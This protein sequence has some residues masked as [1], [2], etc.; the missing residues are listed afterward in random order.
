MLSKRTII[1][2]VVG[3]VITG[4]GIFALVLA[5]GTQTSDID[6]NILVGE[7]RAYKFEALKDS[8]EYLLVMGDRF[9]LTITTPGDGLQ[10]LSTTHNDQ[11]EYDWIVEQDGTNR[12]EIKNTGASDVNI[13][14]NFEYQTDPILYA[15]HIMVIIAGV[16][17]I[18]FSAVFSIRKPRGF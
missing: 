10:V 5:L 18:G 9:N 11:A 7:T 8:S 15:Y 12:I 16:V 2:N 14:A 13:K 4:M 6:E 1:G 17:I 3:G